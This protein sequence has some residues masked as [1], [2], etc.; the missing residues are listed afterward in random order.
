MKK[1]VSR[2]DKIPQDSIINLNN[3]YQE[4]STNINNMQYET[5]S[6]YI[7]SLAKNPDN[8]KENKEKKEQKNREKYM[9]IYKKVQK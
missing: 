5:K 6:D 7:K 1:N 2:N 3:N 8:D 9:L 4:N